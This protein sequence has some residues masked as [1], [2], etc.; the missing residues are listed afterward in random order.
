M[1][2]TQGDAAE[3]NLNVKCCWISLLHFDSGLLRCLCAGARVSMENKT[4]GSRGTVF[5]T[6]LVFATLLRRKRR[7]GFFPSVEVNVTMQE[8]QR[9]TQSTTLESC[10]SRDRLWPIGAQERKRTVLALFGFSCNFVPKVSSNP[11]AHRPVRP[12]IY[13]RGR[14]YLKGWNTEV[15]FIFFAQCH[16]FRF[17][18]ECAAASHDSPPPPAA[19]GEEGGGHVGGKCVGYRESGWKTRRLFEERCRLVLEFTSRLVF[20]WIPSSFWFFYYH[21]LKKWFTFF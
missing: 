16:V 11:G 10:S 9:T 13:R 1:I 20:I 18:E 2:V 12:R 3:W 7:E 4:L 19:E 8:N 21:T 15:V 17:D 5:W 14:F 6:K